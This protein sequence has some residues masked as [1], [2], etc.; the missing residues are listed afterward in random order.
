MFKKIIKTSSIVLLCISTLIQ[1]TTYWHWSSINTNDIQFP[2]S[3]TWGTT[4]MAC[5]VEGNSK[6]DSWTAFE[7]YVHSNGEKFQQV[8]P[9]IA[10]DHWN[11]YKEDIQLIAQ[12]GLT[13]YCFS[14]DWSKIEPQQGQFDESALQ[15]YAD[16]CDECNYYGIKPLIIFKDY[17]DPIWFLNCGGFEKT[18]NITFF[19][20]YCLKVFTKLQGKV[21]DY[22][23]FWTPESYAMLAYWNNNHPPFKHNMQLAATVMKNELEAHVRV[24]HA[25]KTADKNKNIRVGIVK[26]VHKLEPWFT[27]DKLA[28]HLADQMVDAPFYNFFTTGHFKIRMAVP[29]KLNA[30]VHHVNKLAPQSVDFIGINYQ[31]HG[32]IRNFKKMNWDNP[33]EVATDCK[34]FTIYAEGLYDAIK[35][36]SDRMARQLNIPLYITQNGVATTDNAIR[37]L[38]AQQHL[39]A[40][41]QAIKHGY[42]VSGYYYYSLLDG[43]TWSGYSKKF[44][45]F[46]VDRTTLER[47][48]KPGAQYF[49]NAANRFAHRAQ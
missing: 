6:N 5:E 36:V 29:G 25:L 30:N 32:H 41:S 11:R 3:F 49:L 43:Y 38:H 35:E 48:L 42:N 27:W 8:P 21:F 31:S 15:H 47:T 2:S 39:Y 4:T 17:R 12:Q 20:Q 37:A 23:T 44:G 28:C 18:Q 1:G 7:S 45:L 13:S 26:H 46:A 24:Y 14:L 33:K 9:G 22:V 16:V 10:C 19:E 40:V 34:G